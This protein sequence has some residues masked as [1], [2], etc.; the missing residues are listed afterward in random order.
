MQYRYPGL[1][2]MKAQ[3]EW[4]GKFLRYLGHRIVKDK[5]T[6]IA[7]TLTLTS[8]LS[9]IPLLAVVFTFM[10]AMP[11]TQN[12]GNYIQ[13]FIFNNF[14][15]AVS[16]NMEQAVL[17]FV[18]KASSMQPLGFSFLVITVIMLLRTIDRGF[19]Q[20][21]R[22]RQ[23]RKAIIAFLIY[24]LLLI[25]GP[26]FLGMSIALTSYFTSILILTDTGRQIGAQ[27]TIVL[28]WLLTTIGLAIIYMI[29]PNTKV[30]FLH[31]IIGAMVAGF[32]FEL[33]KKLFTTY[34]TSFPLQ[35]IIF[36]A[37]SV[38][39]LFLIWVYLSWLVILLGAEVCHGLE[40]FTPDR[41][42]TDEQSNYFLDSLRVLEVIKKQGTIGHGPDRDEIMKYMA[43]ISD[44]SV[45]E[46]LLEL[47]RIGLID[48]SEKGE[49]RLVVELENYTLK[50]F[51]NNVQWK[52][53]D[54]EMILES[55]FSDKYLAREV[56]SLLQSIEQQTTYSLTQ[57]YR[58]V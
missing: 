58:R 47:Q 46:S 4:I 28:P 42:D 52:V 53:P 56:L 32:L 43:N 35:E 55:E 16:Y 51:I 34:V 24:W 25:L 54:R 41:D 5:L 20:I 19:N 3:M 9:M 29:I 6:N 2:M 40:N 36:G 22:T 1:Y 11:I 10:A 8:L 38:V 37:L 15:P 48:E 13:E 31:S 18:Q 50:Q 49:Y 17:G 14:V 23:R 57:S 30:R 12:L 39:P 45:A 44:T 21:W 33:A 26:L 7:A 27:L